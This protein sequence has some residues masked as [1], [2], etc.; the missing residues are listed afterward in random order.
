MSRTYP[1]RHDF[2]PPPP[3]WASTVRVGENQAHA[4]G[5]LAPRTAR[6]ARELP[7][8][9]VP[10]CTADRGAG[11]LAGRRPDRWLSPLLRPRRVLRRPRG[12]GVGGADGRREL[13][14]PLARCRRAR[15]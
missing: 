11:R 8:R 4:Q 14:A 10:E 15:L 2:V 3:R 6:L 5:S 12:V 1:L 13:G 7:A 9:A